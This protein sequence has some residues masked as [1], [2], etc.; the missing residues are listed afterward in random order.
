MVLRTGWDCPRRAAV[1]IVRAGR[2]ADL[3]WELARNAEGGERRDF[4]LAS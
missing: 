1:A 4:K 2:R 3:S